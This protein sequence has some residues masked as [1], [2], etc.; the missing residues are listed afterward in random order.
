VK[1]LYSIVCALQYDS[2]GSPGD[3]SKSSY[4]EA[5]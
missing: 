1:L 3:G 5:N 2:P 4:K